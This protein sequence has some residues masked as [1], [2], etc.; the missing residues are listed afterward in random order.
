M[1]TLKMLIVGA[2]SS[3]NGTELAK[4][5]VC[6]GTWNYVVA[7]RDQSMIDVEDAEHPL[8]RIAAYVRAMN[9]EFHS[10]SIKFEIHAY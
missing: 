4:V 9:N 8:G 6:G 3:G 2:R 10:T 5:R 7:I 1:Y